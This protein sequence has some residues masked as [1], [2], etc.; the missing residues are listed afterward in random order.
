MNSSV[1]SPITAR[2]VEQPTVTTAP[3]RVVSRPAA[4]TSKPATGGV[5][6]ATSVLKHTVEAGQTYFSISRLYGVS[7]ED[8]LAWNSLTLSDKLSVGQKLT[9]RDSPLSREADSTATGGKKPGASEDIIYHT[10][11]KG[12]TMF[13]ISK[14]YEVSIEQIQQ[15]NELSDNGVKEGQRIKIIKQM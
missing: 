11:Q 4:S 2:P 15:W 3:E 6:P 14:Q 9:I 1:N 7:I 10:V 8:L 5:R 13:R 12:E